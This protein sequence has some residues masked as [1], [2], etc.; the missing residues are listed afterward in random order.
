[1]SQLNKKLVR[2]L[3]THWAQV[4][5]IIVVV[6]LGVIMFSGP[7]SAQRDLRDSVNAIYRRTRYEDFSVSVDSAP[8][9]V[10]A[11][12][13]GMPNMKAVEGRLVRDLLAT[14][15]GRQLTLRVISVPD[16]GRPTV[17][18]LIVESGHYPPPGETGQCLAEHH[19][20]T[21]LKL[22]PGDSVT[23]SNGAGDVRLRV[24][25]TVV[26]PEYLRLVRSRSEYISDPA[27]FGVVF[28]RYS[29]VQ[30]LLGAGDTVNNIVAR[31]R[32]KGLLGTTM[33]SARV[34]LTPYNVTGLTT[35]SDEPSA[36]TLDL[37]IKDI[38]KL[39][40]FFAVL[41]WP[42]RRSRST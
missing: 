39:A 32:A 37:E 1:M 23:I 5:A 4:G 11:Q 22:Q 12:F 6:A 41:P 42:W 29:E 10:V 8:A 15:K 18:D 17:N 40:I 14:V 16:A 7:L 35:G 24:A 13:A 20:S 21:E 3:V 27:Q 30:G 19:L 9:G 34:L 25:G 2:D 26:S 36:V 38:G 33:E 31:V 28:M